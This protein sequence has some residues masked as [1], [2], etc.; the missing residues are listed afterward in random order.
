CSNLRPGP[1][2]L[3]SVHP[4]VLASL[5][6]LHTTATRHVHECPLLRARIFDYDYL[7]WET[8]YFLD[9]FVAGLRK[10]EIRH[11]PVID[12]ELHRLAQPV[13]AQARGALHPDCQCQTIMIH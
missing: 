7:R 2:R 3:E 4:L 5:V 1:P 9:R 10:L 6:T 13:D 11:R 8:T 12:E